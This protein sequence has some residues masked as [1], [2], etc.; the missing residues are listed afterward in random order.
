VVTI[1]TVVVLLGAAQGALLPFD[2]SCTKDD[3]GKIRLVDDLIN[4]PK[5][6]INTQAQKG[7]LEVCL[8]YEKNATYQYGTVCDDNFGNNEAYYMCKALP[9]GE[10]GDGKAFGRDDKT[11]EHG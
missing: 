10:Y 3:V 4:N 8:Y 11:M 2:Y 5:D 1:V 9:Y 7:R 6:S